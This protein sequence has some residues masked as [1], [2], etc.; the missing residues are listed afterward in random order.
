MRRRR[1]FTP[2]A[3]GSLEARLSLSG[4]ASPAAIVQAA[5]AAVDSTKAAVV[6]A[7]KFTWPRHNTLKGF[8]NQVFGK[9]HHKVK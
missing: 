8:W 5:H 3:L 9:H 6:H 7:E 4:V 1:R 2:C